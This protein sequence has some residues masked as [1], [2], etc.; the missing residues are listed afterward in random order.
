MI[1]ST[2]YFPPI[3]FFYHAVKTDKIVVEAHENFLKQTYR[4]RCTIYTAN[5]K[6]DLSV[7]L[8]K[9]RRNHL[10]LKE[11]KISYSLPWHKMHLKALHSAYNKSPF[12]MY[13]QAELETFFTQ[14]HIWLLDFNMKITQHAFKL[15][16][17][18]P[19]L[20]LS[21]KY[22]TDYNQEPDYRSSISPKK[23]SQLPFPAYTQVFDEKFGFIPNLSLL[24]L[25]F[26]C[27]PE[28]LHYLKSF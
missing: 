23:T 21:E 20:V 1:F 3:E 7:S 26:N 4:N 12:F 28:S 2:A 11:V 9:C 17:Y 10:P 22:I 14:K 25:L 6:L 15:L 8:E 19:T 18:S 27:G 16:K 13:Y 5:G 24:D